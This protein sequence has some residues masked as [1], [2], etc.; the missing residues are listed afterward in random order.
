MVCISSKGSHLS[1]LGIIFNL[2]FVDLSNIMSC[3][4]M[5]KIKLFSI[6][7]YLTVKDVIDIFQEVSLMER[8]SID[9]RWR[10]EWSA[11]HL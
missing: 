2:Y 9:K 4:S 10:W 3:L 11:V 5:K 6:F 8:V 7:F 1:L